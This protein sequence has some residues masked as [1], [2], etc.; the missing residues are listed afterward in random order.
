MRLEDDDVVAAV[1]G[2]G[3]D[4]VDGLLKEVIGNLGHNHGQG[5]AGAALQAQGNGVG[6]L[7][8]ALGLFHHQPLGFGADFVTVAQRPRHRRSRQVQGVRNILDGDGVQA[9]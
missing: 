5:L 4:A 8:E 7:V 6:P 1:V 3:F 2:N 9:R